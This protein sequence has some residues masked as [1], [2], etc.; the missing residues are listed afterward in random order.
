MSTAKD[1]TIRHEK[2]TQR[3]LDRRP[4]VP[5]TELCSQPPA[6]AGRVGVV[7]PS[8][9]ATSIDRAARTRRL[10]WLELPRTRSTG[11]RDPGCEFPITTFQEVAAVWDR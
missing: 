9:R 5:R 11:K 8:A 10:R 6:Y 4:R 2:L 7:M 3:I 1:L